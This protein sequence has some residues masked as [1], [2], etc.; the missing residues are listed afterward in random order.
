[1]Q[2]RGGPRSANSGGRGG[3]PRSWSYRGVAKLRSCGEEGVRAGKE[4]DGARGADEGLNPYRGTGGGK[5]E[6]K[7]QIAPGE[8]G[9]WP[10]ASTSTSNL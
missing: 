9:R 6:G 2:G 1:M 7:T 10:L 5:G 4:G 8:G 3:G